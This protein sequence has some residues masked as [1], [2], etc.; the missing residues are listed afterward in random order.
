MG[1]A[2]GRETLVATVDPTTPPRWDDATF[3]A[4][5]WAMP[6]GRWSF[7]LDAEGLSLPHV[8]AVAL[9][10]LGLVDGVPF[11]VHVG[12]DLGDVVV[13]AVPGGKPVA[14]RPIVDGR[15]VPDGTVL[16]PGRLDL[17]TVRALAVRAARELGFSALVHA[18]LSSAPVAL[19]AADTLTA[20]HASFGIAWLPWQGDTVPSGA[21]LPGRIDVEAGPGSPNRRLTVAAGLPSPGVRTYGASI[22]PHV[23]PWPED[24]RG[25]IVGLPPGAYVVTV[26]GVARSARLTDDAPAAAVSMR[27]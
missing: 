5:A 10:V 15:P 7:E 16:A 11:Y 3:A 6:S 23:V 25:S 18:R 9:H 12:P 21:P 8:P 24:G 17:T 22:P 2:P 4:F 14:G 1:G 26:D 13:D 20:W 27:R 19:P